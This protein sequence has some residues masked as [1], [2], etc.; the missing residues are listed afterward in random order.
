[1]RTDVK[2]GIA[3]GVSVILICVLYFVFAGNKPQ[4]AAQPTPAARNIDR[5]PEITRRTEPTSFPSLGERSLRDVLH[6]SGTAVAVTTMPAGTGV[7]TML[8][9]S[10]SVSVSLRGPVGTSGILSGSS[11]V[12]SAATPDSYV[13]KPGDSFWKI[14]ETVYGSGKYVTLIQQ[15]NPGLSTLQPGQKIKI[16]AKPA[17]A[18]AVTPRTASTQ[19]AGAASTGGNYT[20]VAGDTLTRIAEKQMGGGGSANVAAIVAANPGINPNSLQVGQRLVIPGARAS[21]SAPPARASVVP[22]VGGGSTPASGGDLSAR[23]RFR[24]YASH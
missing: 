13:I 23:P 5:T 18:V 16:P 6:S 19:P 3:V 14:S 4:Q 12:L 1:M 8:S 20:V 10:G 9:P 17:D 2:I 11:S 22:S 21:S 24:E 15:A 7:L